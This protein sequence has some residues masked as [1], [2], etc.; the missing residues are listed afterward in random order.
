MEQFL[1]Q[2][3][4]DRW[5]EIPQFESVRIQM[6]ELAVSR[7]RE[8]LQQQPT[9]ASLRS[10]AAMAYRRC[11]NL[12]RMV[13]QFAEASELYAEAAAILKELLR[14]NPGRSSRC[15]RS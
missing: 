5:S 14:R 12:Y 7:Y 15:A 1:I 11:A 2:I 6:V 10:D 4:D 3:G 9:D 8:L 13:G